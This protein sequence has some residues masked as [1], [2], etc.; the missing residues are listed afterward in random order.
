MTGLKLK[1]EA[2]FILFCISQKKLIKSL[3]V[4]EIYGCQPMRCC[5]QVI[6]Y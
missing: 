5:W 4:G 6:E 1:S 3:N 2:G